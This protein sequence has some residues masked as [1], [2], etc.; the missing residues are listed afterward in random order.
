MVSITKT[1][2]QQAAFC[3]GFF[4][5]STAPVMAQV[6][7]PESLLRKQEDQQRA[8]TLTRELLGGVLDVQLRQLDENGL[9]DQEIYRDIKLMRQNLNHLVETEMTKVV[10]LL[11][12]AQRLPAERREAVFIDARQQIRTIVRQLA[13]ERQNLLKRLKI[14]ELVEQVRRIIRQQTIVQVNTKGLPSEAQS[15][16]EVLTLKAIEDQR[17][18]KELFL[19]LV[20][21]LVDMKTWSGTL[22]SAAAD[23]LRILKV[24]EVGRHLDTAGR[25]LQA[26]QFTLAYD[27]QAL[28]IKGLNELL[29]IVERTQGGLNS[30]FQAAL[31]R[32][33]GLIDQQKQLRDETKSLGDQQPPPAEMVE[34]QAQLQKEIASLTESIQ[35]NPKAEAHIQQA[36][37]AALDAAA[38]LLDSQSVKATADQGQ[39][40]GNLAA[41]ELMLRNQAKQNSPDRSAEELADGIKRLHEAKATLTEAKAKQ[42]SAKAEAKQNAQSAAPLLAEIAKSTQATLD[43]LDLPAGVQSALTQTT[44]SATDGAKTLEAT[45]SEKLSAGQELA[46]TNVTHALDRALATVDAAVSDAERQESAVKIGELARAAEVL[47]RAAA[48]ERDIATAADALAESKSATPDDAATQAGGVSGT[49]TRC[50]VNCPQDRR[51][52]RP[53]RSGSDKKYC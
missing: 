14:V 28:S 35:E 52:T 47:E 18:V 48:E 26:V 9:S 44:Q 1:L 33:R 23:G 20:D 42:E 3:A 51:S 38:S 40:L 31:D 7:E 8:R 36:E 15:R 22:S 11:A 29:R 24:T 4:V 34:R 39:V 16:Q 45:T 5:C 27:E 25:Q 17:D 43:S 30:E 41:L 6:L 50:S 19:H 53:D 32:V 12:Q 10:D 21:T 37:T 46:L 13:V 2:W 49:P